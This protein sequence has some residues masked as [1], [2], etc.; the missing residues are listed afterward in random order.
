M[1]VTASGTGTVIFGEA[2]SSSTEQFTG[3]WKKTFTGDDAK[4]FLTFSVTGDF[5]G[6]DDQKLSCAVT[7]NGK[8]VS[9]KEAT[10]A[11]ASVFCSTNG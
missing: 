6:G 5:T 2:G 9:H 7:K 11:A 1:S 3:E 8:E 10:G 4:K